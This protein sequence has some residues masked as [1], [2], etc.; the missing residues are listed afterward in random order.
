MNSDISVPQQPYLKSIL[1]QQRKD[2]ALIADIEKAVR[3]SEKQ[4]DDLVYSLYE[5]NRSEVRI[6]ENYLK[7]A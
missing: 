1:G 7:R 4:I 5:L 6:I 3:D 2:T